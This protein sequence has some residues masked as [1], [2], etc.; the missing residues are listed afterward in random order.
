MQQFV[1]DKQMGWEQY[2]DGKG[3][4]N[5]YGQKYAIHAIPQMWLIGRDG[6][7]VDFN[8][9][10]SLPEKISKLL[11]STDGLR[12]RRRHRPPK[13]LANLEARTFYWVASDFK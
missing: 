8:A 13:R 4:G 11:K 6:K 9:R 10:A 2:F 3:W 7:I 1:K 5:E 12:K